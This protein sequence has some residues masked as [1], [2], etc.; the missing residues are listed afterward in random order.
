MTSVEAKRSCVRRSSSY[1]LARFISPMQN[2]I[3]E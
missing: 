2:S 3:G 1:A